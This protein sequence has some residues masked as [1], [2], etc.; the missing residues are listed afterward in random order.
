MEARYEQAITSATE[1][2]AMPGAAWESRHLAYSHR[3]WASFEL[4]RCEAAAQD[5]IV[6]L[7]L[8]GPNYD[9]LINLTLYFRCSGRADLSL[10]AVLLAKTLQEQ[11][12]QP[13]GMMTY[14]HLGWS[15]QALGENEKAVEAYTLGIPSQP[16]F[17]FVYYRRALAYEALGMAGE[18]NRDFQRALSLLYTA[19]PLMRSGAI[20]DQLLDD[21]QLRG[22]DINAL[23]EVGG[24]S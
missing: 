24:E 19:T 9:D 18:A 7:M 22:F 10:Q 4:G 6:A 8:H 12:H 16:D 1:C 5:Q 11:K 23:V 14:Y 17:P 13:P 2:L 3:A 15:Y 20:Y 21:L